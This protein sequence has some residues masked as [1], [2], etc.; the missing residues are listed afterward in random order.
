MDPGFKSL[1]PLLATAPEITLIQNY[2]YGNGMPSGNNMQMT[3]VQ[4]A[5]IQEGV[6]NAQNM[7]LEQRRINQAIAQEASRLLI[8]ARK[9]LL[10]SKDN[11]IDSKNK[12]T[13]QIEN[14]SESG[15]KIKTNDAI[16][17][18]YEIIKKD[19]EEKKMEKK[20]ESDVTSNGN[21]K[22]IIES[23]ESQ[24]KSDKQPPHLMMGR[25]VESEGRTISTPIVF[26]IRNGIWRSRVRYAIKQYCYEEESGKFYREPSQIN[27]EGV[28]VVFFNGK[29]EADEI[30]L[31]CPIDM[32]AYCSEDSE[33]NS[34]VE[35]FNELYLP[36][37][38]R[39]FLVIKKNFNIALNHYYLV[40]EPLLGK[41]PP[42]VISKKND[43]S[44]KADVMSIRPIFSYC[45]K[46]QRIT[47]SSYNRA[48]KR[49]KINGFML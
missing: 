29:K 32:P 30:L 44:M 15:E 4:L 34:F 46:D 28:F 40:F 3:H 36:D 16:D 38:E 45:V 19:E 26:T 7:L 48:V 27:G 37:F 24:M 12:I 20:E 33:F 43:L 42:Y 9:E 35:N 39:L 47:F 41:A 10:Q 1:M 5:A 8:E 11:L 21:G 25:V 23:I 14:K 31:I 17:V 22:I 18:S 49:K 6:L 2:N 13:A